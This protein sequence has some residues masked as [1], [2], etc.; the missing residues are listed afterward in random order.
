M[1]WT[2]YRTV[3]CVSPKGY[4]KMNLSVND[5]INLKEL[6]EKDAYRFIQKLHLEK[7]LSTGQSLSILA[8]VLY[9]GAAKYYVG[10]KDHYN[11]FDINIFFR[12]TLYPESCISTYG[13]PAP[14]EEPHNGKKVEVMRNVPFG[15]EGNAVA[16][17]KNYASRSN[18]KRWKRISSEPVIF[19]Y[20][21]IQILPNLY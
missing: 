1:G 10:D 20:P 17:V 19:L 16:I 11:D 12:S 4:K 5:L 6:V 7:R 14:I 13:K 18:S 8:I 2:A 15:Y 21:D 9:G 3:F